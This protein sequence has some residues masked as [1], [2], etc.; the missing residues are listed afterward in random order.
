MTKM[1]SGI[2]LILIIVGAAALAFVFFRANEKIKLITITSEGKLEP[3]EIKI[4]NEE[5]IKIKNQDDAKHT[6][7][8]V[9]NNTN[10]VTDLE[11]NKT[12]A[13][14]VFDDNSRNEIA[15]ADNKEAKTTILVGDAPA[16]AEIKKQPTSVTPPSSNPPVV[17]TNG[18]PLPDTGAENNF[19]YLGILFSGLL[20]FLVSGKLLPSYLRKYLVKL[21]GRTIVVHQEE[22]TLI[23]FK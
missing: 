1:I 9:G 12:S 4:T 11:Q 7:R 19:I 8:N 22:T 23:R 14:I 5:V 18:E 17:D 16:A 6:V 3:G 13:E 15:L 21:S 10:L 20:V 2:L